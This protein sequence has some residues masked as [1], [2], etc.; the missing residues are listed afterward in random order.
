[1]SGRGQLV[2]EQVHARS[3]ALPKISPRVKEQCAST[4]V[5]HIIRTVE[6]FDV[7]RASQIGAAS[8]RRMTK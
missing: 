8:D 4:R 7:S 5:R 1:M 3:T 6:A 2:P